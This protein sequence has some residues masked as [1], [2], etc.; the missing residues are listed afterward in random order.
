M[1]RA[2]NTGIYISKRFMYLK[3][4]ASALVVLFLAGSHDLQGARF[5]FTTTTRQ[6]TAAATRRAKHRGLRTTRQSTAAAT[7][8]AKHRGLRT[9]RQPT[10]AAT[11]QAK[12]RGLRTT[13]QP[14]AAAASRA[15]HRG[16]RTTRQPTATAKRSQHRHVQR[17]C[18]SHWLPQRGQSAAEYDE[19]APRLLQSGSST[20]DVTVEE[21]AKA[22]N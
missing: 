1:Q 10:A 14:T 8:R 12:H 11:R 17:G 4:C 5:T 22:A 9:T 6:P 18:R 2:S 13:R 15:K 3:L 7:R 16:L 20:A 21:A 19:A